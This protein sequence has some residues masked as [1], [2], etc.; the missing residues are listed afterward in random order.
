LPAAPMVDPSAEFTALRWESGRAPFE[1]RILRGQGHHW[2][3][4]EPLDPR[5]QRLIGPNNEALD[6]TAMAIEFVDKH[7]RLAA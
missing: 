5:I 7:V 6:A 2:P 1:F 4:G 3:A